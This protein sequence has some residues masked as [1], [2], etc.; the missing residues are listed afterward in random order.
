MLLPFADVLKLA[1]PVKVMAAANETGA[2]RVVE[3]AR[4]TAPAPV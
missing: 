4:E 1:G 2:S 3:P